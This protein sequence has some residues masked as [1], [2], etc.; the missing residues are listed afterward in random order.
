MSSVEE[1]RAGIRGRPQTSPPE[2]RRSHDTWFDT[3]AERVLGLPEG[4]RP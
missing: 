3:I 4:I 2:P 1:F